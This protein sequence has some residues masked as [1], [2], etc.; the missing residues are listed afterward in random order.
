MVKTVFLDQ[1]L[2]KRKLTYEFD[3]RCAR[4]LNIAYRQLAQR[5]NRSFFLFPAVTLVIC[6]NDGTKYGLTH[7]HFISNNINDA[8][9][10]YLETGQYNAVKTTPTNAIPNFVRIQIYE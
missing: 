9:P 1:K 6:W 3:Q 10:S 7:D 8:V 4:S 2:Q 5:C